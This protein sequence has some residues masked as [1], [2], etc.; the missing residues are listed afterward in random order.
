MFS[1]VRFLTME[2]KILCSG[3]HKEKK[4]EKLKAILY[5][6]TPCSILKV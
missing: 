5:Q 3:K 6:V 2:K 1:K 4:P